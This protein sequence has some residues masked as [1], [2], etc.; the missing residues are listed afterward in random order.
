[1]AKPPKHLAVPDYSETPPQ[2]GEVGVLVST[3]ENKHN[4]PNLH[5]FQ[6]RWQSHQSIYLCQTTLE[7]HHKTERLEVIFVL[8][9]TYPTKPLSTTHSQRGAERFDITRLLWNITAKRKGWSLF[10]FLRIHIQPD[11]HQPHTP[12]AGRN[13]STSPD[14]SGTP[15]QGGKVGVWFSTTENK[16]HQPNRHHTCKRWVKPSSPDYSDAPTQSG[17]FISSRKQT[18]HVTKRITDTRYYTNQ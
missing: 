6:T 10:S 15:P 11:H 16:H 4:Q 3:K 9:N 8:T 5:H 1:M 13:V 12:N 17:K 2:S 18:T 7:H 14:C